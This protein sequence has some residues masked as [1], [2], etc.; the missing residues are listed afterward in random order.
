V[1]HLIAQYGLLIV[2]GVI[3]AGEIG[4]P[5]LVPGEVALLIAG[6]QVVHSVPMLIGAI[7]LF[8]A[9]DLAA[10]VTI[11]T[12]ARTGGNRLLS[13]LLRMMCRKGMKPE[14]VFESCRHRLGGYDPFVVF[15]TRLV[16]IFRLYASIGTGLIRIRFKH[17]VAGAAP[18]A[19]LWA[20]IPLTVGY[21]LRSQ[22]GSV[23]RGYPTM[24]RYVVAASMCITVVAILAGWLRHA[25]SAEAAMRRMRFIVGMVAVVGA[26]TRLLTFA[27]Q[28]HGVAGH[29]WMMP[30]AP[31]VSVWVTL[32]G[33]AGLGLLWVAG[34]DLRVICTRHRRAGFG[35]VSAL[36]WVSLLAILAVSA[37]GIGPS[38]ATLA[39]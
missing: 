16:P 23:V 34:H 29:R 25:G 24:M 7:V 30:V 21:L 3:F 14:A 27:L 18:A 1:A 2:A 36:A 33:L 8:G 38:V 39:I 31:Q 26:L 28:E 15:A 35:R 6:T 10:T 19:W 37:T 5:T 13:H 22:I 11:H 9:V 12:T 17:F 4:L 20:S 32:I